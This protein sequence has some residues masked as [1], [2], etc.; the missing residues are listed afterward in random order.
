LALQFFLDIPGIPGDSTSRLFP[1]TI[2]LLS[3]SLGFSSSQNPVSPAAGSGFGITFVVRPNLL[4]VTKRFDRS[5]I[6]LFR[7]LASGQILRE[8]TLYIVRSA[9]D[10]PQTILKYTFKGVTVNI[11]NQSAEV[12]DDD[13]IPDETVAFNYSTITMESNIFEDPQKVTYDRRSNRVS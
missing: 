9:I 4:T 7:T 10:N 12:D 11:F 8:M 3:Y 6:P 13:N 1:N 2:E 5:S